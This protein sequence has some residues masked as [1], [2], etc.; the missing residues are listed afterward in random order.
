MQR[1]RFEI[2]GARGEN[3]TPFRFFGLFGE[4]ED[5]RRSRERICGGDDLPPIGLVA[6]DDCGFANGEKLDSRIGVGYAGK[7]P[8]EFRKKLCE[9]RRSI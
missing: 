4:Y 1:V 5:E 8:V 7:L 3:F 9:P 2:E 6:E